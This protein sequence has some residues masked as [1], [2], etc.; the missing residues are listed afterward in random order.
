MN[1]DVRHRHLVDA[2]RLQAGHRVLEI[3]PGHGVTLSLITTAVG[4]GEVWA[5][6][7]SAK[8]IAAATRRNQEQVAA[9]RLHLE[10]RRVQ[11][12]DFGDASFDR[13]VAMRVREIWDDAETVLPSVGR[14]LRPDG[15]LCLGIDAP[16][17][18]SVEEACRTVSAQLA[19]HDFRGIE[20]AWAQDMHLAAV[21]AGPPGADAQSRARASA[22]TS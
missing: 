17:R 2:A 6:D 19:G 14:W 3:G 18:A 13:I 20:V 15:L 10:C 8:M 4:T 21:I 7:R 5:V 9:G 11:D 12:C 16:Q 22:G 1:D